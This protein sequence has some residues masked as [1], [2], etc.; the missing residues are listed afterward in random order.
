MWPVIFAN[1]SGSRNSRNKGHGKNTGFTV[2]APA[3]AGLRP[4][5]PC[6]GLVPGPH[7]GTSIPRPSDLPLKFHFLDPPCLFCL[8]N[9]IICA[10]Y[11]SFIIC[12]W[13]E[14]YTTGTSSCVDLSKIL[15]QG[16]SGVSGASKN[17]FTIHFNRATLCVSAVFA[18]VQCLSVCHV[19][20]LYPHG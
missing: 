20:G 4:Q 3:S 6:W 11:C 16:Q 1:S 8:C 13:G 10:F 18:V 5:A 7:R 19:G 9:C 15:G 14:A 2:N 17:S 12:R